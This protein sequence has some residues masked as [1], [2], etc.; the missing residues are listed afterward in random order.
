MAADNTLTGFD[1]E[2][3]NS[4]LKGSTK[5]ALNGGNLIVYVDSKD[6]IPLLIQITPEGENILKSYPEH[7]NSVSV[8]TMKEV[9]EEVK[10]D[11]P[12]KSYG[13]MLWSH[14]SNWFPSDMTFL[15]AFG[16]DKSNWM[17]LSQLK[18]VLADSSFDFIIFD[19]CYMA[20]IEVLYELKD[21]AN[22]IMAAP[23]EILGSGFPYS[24]IISHL[25]KVTPDL[26]GICDEF[27]NYYANSSDPFATIALVST[28]Q[29]EPL[30]MI[31][32]NIMQEN[33]DKTENI[34][35][36][37]LQR[38]FRPSYYGMYDFDDY[39]SRIASEK[40]YTQFQTTLEKA[41]IYKKNTPSFMIGYSGG[42]YINH[43]CGLSSFI[44]SDS[45]SSS[46]KQKYAELDWYKAVY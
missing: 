34:E 5:D 11:F 8:E 20:G 30:A 23:S 24:K 39:I 16:Q 22:Y 46:I 33:F 3:I 29:L 15:K 41:V 32:R 28:S 7:V 2:N 25:F 43:F 27:Y 17:E 18:E 13:L 14:G 38:Y 19:A 45:Y 44:L 12:A 31:T 21:K 35:L 36:S 37:S 26:T 4:M 9:I 42:Y 6:T 1:K 40:Q 10:T